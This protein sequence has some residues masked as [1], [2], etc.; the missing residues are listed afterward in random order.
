MDGARRENKFI[1]N[2]LI[3][4]QDISKFYKETTTKHIF[5]KVSKLCEIGKHL[6]G[7]MI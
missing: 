3:G 2:A 6:V 7:E 4:Q 1:Q 5:A